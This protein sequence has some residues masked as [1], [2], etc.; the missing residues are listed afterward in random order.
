MTAPHLTQPRDLDLA[1]SAITNGLAGLALTLGLG[2]AVQL[3]EIV[4][5]LF[6]QFGALLLPMLQCRNRRDVS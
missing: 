4:Y 2:L 5:L 1:R 6:E 3:R